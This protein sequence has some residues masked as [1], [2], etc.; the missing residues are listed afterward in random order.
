MGPELAPPVPAQIPPEVAG[1]AGRDAELAQL[2][3]ALPSPGGT[4][5]VVLTGTAG[6]GKTA[7]SVRFAHEVADRFPEG[8]LY[9]NLHGFDPS[10]A[11]GDPS[12]ALRGFLEALGVPGSLVPTAVEAQTGLLRSMLDGKRILLLLDNAQTTSQVRP[13]LPG[14]SGCMVVVTSRDQLAGLVAAEGARLIPLDVLSEDEARDM[15]AARLGAAR[16]AAEPAAVA[17]LI[18]QS[19]RLPLALSVASA[20]AVTRPGIALAALTAELRDARVR[21]D[22]LEAGDVATRP[23]GRLLVVAGAAVIV[24]R[25]DV[26]PAGRDSRSRPDRRRRGEP[27]RGPGR[28]G[29]VRADRAVPGVLADRG[30]RRPARVPRPAARLRRRAGPGRGRGRRSGRGAA[31][32]ARPLPANLARRRAEGLSRAVQDHAAGG[33]AGGNAPSGSSPTRPSPAGSGPSRRR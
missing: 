30:R 18:R 1:F 15:L 9:V 22:P 16:L 31:P 4:P 12:A 3:A 7:L 32:R 20:R 11:P 21:L 17:E 24:G 5:I 2:R 29:A 13:L 26:P 33:A 10:A 25:A 14:S 27:G 28:G 19:A 8:Q 6:V 23:A